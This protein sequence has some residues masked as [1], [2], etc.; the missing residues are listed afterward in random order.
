MG[1]SAWW[2][3]QA[4]EPAGRMEPLGVGAQMEA[5]NESHGAEK[6]LLEKGTC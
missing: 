4:G 3:C 2:W 6:K 1:L 5:G